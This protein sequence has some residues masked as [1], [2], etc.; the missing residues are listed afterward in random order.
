MFFPTDSVTTW[1]GRGVVWTLA[2]ELLLVA[3]SPFELALWS[4]H[5]GT[6][7]SRRVEAKRALLDHESE[8]HAGHARSAGG[9]AG[10]SAASG[11]D[12]N[13]EPAGTRLPAQLQR[14][15]H[16]RQLAR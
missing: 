14:P 4:T 6:R 3:L 2:F 16:A 1:L 11:E 8:G 15:G 10:A 7:I 12:P 9:Q 5:R 13:G